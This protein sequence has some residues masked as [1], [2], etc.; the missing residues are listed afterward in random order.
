MS[1]LSA[2]KFHVTYANDE[3]FAIF[4]TRGRKIFF[5]CL[6]GFLLL[7]PAITSDYV[8]YVLNLW[9]IAIIAVSGLFVLVGMTGLISLGH[10]IFFGVG[11]VTA[12][13]LATKLNAPMWITI[14]CAGVVAAIIGTIVGTP[15]LRLKGF[16][17]ALATLAGHYII[18]FILW[19]WDWACGSQGIVLEAPTLFGKDLSNYKSYYY[20][21]LTLTVILYWMVAN[22]KLTRVGRAFQA[23][24]DRDIAAEV[25]GIQLWKYK[26]LSFAL[27]SFYAGVAGAVLVHM[28][29]LVPPE[30]FTVT[31]SIEYLA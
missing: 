28:L 5:C 6:L 14:P 9:G 17:L 31:L 24:R 22:L 29:T 3:I 7:V 20:L 15:A 30:Y 2:G 1:R 23:I 4:Q 25:I 11:G 10:G 19:N 21:I 12:G 8:I 27:S 16:Y 26:L 13:I 18:F